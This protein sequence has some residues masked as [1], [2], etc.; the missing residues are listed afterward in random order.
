MN[1]LVRYFLRGLL[2]VVPLGVT[3]YVFYQ[4]FIFLDQFNP[5]A[6]VPGLGLIL[7]FLVVALIGLLA[8]MLLTENWNQWL[9]RQL[10]KAPL[11]NMIYAGVR[12]LLEAFV[13][14]KERFKKPVLVEMGQGRQLYRVGFITDHSFAQL[15]K[16]D[17][18]LVSVYLPHSYNIS[19]N[20]YLVPAKQLK[21][22]DL[23][24]GDVMKYVVSGGLSAID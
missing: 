8:K 6:A 1:R 7:V 14:N 4:I 22:I 3:I 2:I 15:A 20:L 13:E 17:E 21:E 5:V 11:V 16:L 18:D 12:D 23:K 10:K 9:H 19:G 24:S